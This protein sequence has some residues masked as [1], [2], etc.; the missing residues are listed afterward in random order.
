MMAHITYLSEEGMERKFDR[1]RRRAGRPDDAGL[2][3][4]GRALP[5]PPGGDLPRPLRPATYLY[6]SRVM[7]YFDPF[8]ERRRARPTRA[9]CSSRSPRTGASAPST[10][11]IEAQLRERWR[12]GRHHEVDSPWGHDSFL[13]DVPEYHA[14]VREFIVSGRGRRALLR[15]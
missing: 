1:A 9:S 4:R 8:A 7:D 3:L 13:M 14:L 12:G 15:V 2:R 5:R 10:R 6:L 11:Y